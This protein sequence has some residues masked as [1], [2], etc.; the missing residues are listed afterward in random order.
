MKKRTPITS[1][2]EI[3]RKTQTTADEELIRTMTKMLTDS[4]PEVVART[5]VFAIKT[6]THK[7]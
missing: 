4:S 5:I 7:S 6:L 3:V 1:H 2:A